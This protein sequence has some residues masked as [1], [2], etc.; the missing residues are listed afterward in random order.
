M[1]GRPAFE[2]TLPA[3]LPFSTSVSKAARGPGVPVSEAAGIP[4]SILLI[5]RR[6]PACPRIPITTVTE[7]RGQRPTLLIDTARLRISWSA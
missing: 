1:L 4:P 5:T 3:L 7:N 2:P 6:A